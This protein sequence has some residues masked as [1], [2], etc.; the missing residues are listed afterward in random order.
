MSDNIYIIFV[1]ENVVTL[2]WGYPKPIIVDHDE[3]PF[4]TKPIQL[5]TNV[6][7]VKI[8]KNILSKVT[9]G[10]SFGTNAPAVRVTDKEEK[11]LE[12]KLVIAQLYSYNGRDYTARYKNV[13]A[14]YVNK[15]IINPF[16]ANYDPQ[17]IDPLYSGDYFIPIYT[18]KN[19]TVSFNYSSFSIPGPSGFYKNNFIILF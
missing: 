10:V 7:E 2:T 13:E 6:S 9:E 12:G 19:G 16:P 8:I 17:S 15:R 14:G 18:D 5:L 11:P 3:F 4:Y 1:C